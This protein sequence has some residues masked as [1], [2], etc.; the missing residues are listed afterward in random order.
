M[1]KEVN[2]LLDKNPVNAG[3]YERAADTWTLKKGNTFVKAE[4]KAYFCYTTNEWYAMCPGSTS[5]NGWDKAFFTTKKV[6]RTY[7]HTSTS[8]FI[9]WDN[10]G[11]SPSWGSFCLT[12]AQGKEHGRTSRNGSV[13]S[14]E[15][16]SFYSLGDVKRLVTDSS[17]SMKAGDMYHNASNW[18]F[19]TYSTAPTRSPRRSL[20]TSC[21]SKAMCTSRFSRR[22]RRRPSRP[23][24]PTP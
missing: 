24:P 5:T 9:S 11:S 14:R 3:D 16:S 15:L 20:P 21:T 22:R 18:Y 13:P 8:P 4:G 23:H 10:G 12:T 6:G 19:D 2:D 7:K 17:Y 1:T